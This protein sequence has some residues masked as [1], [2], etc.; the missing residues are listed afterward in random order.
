MWKIEIQQEDVRRVIGT[1]WDLG[2]LRICEEASRYADGSFDFFEAILTRH[3]YHE[4]GE[5]QAYEAAHEAVERAHANEHGYMTLFNYCRNVF[6]VQTHAGHHTTDVTIAE[7]DSLSRRR[8]EF[9]FQD[10]ARE[11]ADEEEGEDED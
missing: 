1:D 5:L 2:D 10:L 8:F 9:S 4:L 7:D 3:L 11:Q 6:V